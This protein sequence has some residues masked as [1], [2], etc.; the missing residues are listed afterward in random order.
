MTKE[1][2]RSHTGLRGIAALIVAPVHMYCDEFVQGFDKF[3]LPFLNSVFAVDVF[4][5]LSGFIL[6]FVYHN[7]EGTMNSSLI[8]SSKILQGNGLQN[9]A[10][11]VKPPLP[12][13]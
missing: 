13:L 10:K 12:K 11:G 2:L 4:F 6:P 1:H 5:V 8:T 9:S 3:I 7:Q